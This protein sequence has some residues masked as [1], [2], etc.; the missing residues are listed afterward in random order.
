MYKIFAPLDFQAKNKEEIEESLECGL[1]K[2]HAY[3]V[4]AVRFIELDAKSRSFLFFAAVERQMMIRLQ[5]PWGEKE[6]N[7]P[8][9]DGSREWEQVINNLLISLQFLFVRNLGHRYRGFSLILHIAAINIFYWT[10][11]LSHL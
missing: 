3:A 4:T 6:W 10:L 9:S 7:G 1:V 8:W 5:N 2:G 11:S